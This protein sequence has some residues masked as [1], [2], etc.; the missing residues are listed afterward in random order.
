[1]MCTE[2]EM[3]LLYFLL[4]IRKQELGSGAL[5]L[6]LGAWESGY[7]LVPTACRALSLPHFSRRKGWAGSKRL[8]KKKK[9]VVSA[10]FLLMPA[11][12]FE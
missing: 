11:F 8:K 3:D 1:M 10:F 4:E 9:K 2:E 6:F 7:N 12:S 5:L